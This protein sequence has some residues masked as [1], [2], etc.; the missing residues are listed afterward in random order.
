V[1]LEGALFANGD[2]L[3]PGGYCHF[4]AVPPCTT[5]PLATR[6]AFVVVFDGPFDVEVLDGG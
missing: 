3:G 5:P 2:V 4:P 1:V 6:A